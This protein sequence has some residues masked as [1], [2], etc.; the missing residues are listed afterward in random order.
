M[1]G[2]GAEAEEAAAAEVVVVVGVAVLV[3]TAAPRPPSVPLTSEMGGTCSCLSA[4]PKRGRG[5]VQW[6]RSAVEWC[7]VVSAVRVVGVPHPS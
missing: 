1:A 4:L 5:Q 2:D 3:P 7:G 6:A